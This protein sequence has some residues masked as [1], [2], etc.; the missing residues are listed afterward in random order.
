MDKKTV[1]AIISDFRKSLESAGIKPG[2]I[3]LY[4]SYAS[5]NFRPDSDIDL[6]VIS[7]DF[8]GKGYWQRIDLLSAAIYEVFQPIEAIAM[9][10]QEWENGDSLIIDYARDGEVVYG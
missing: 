8:E 1:L 4:G 2:K 9:T 3:L 5:G 6:I 7:E 10:P